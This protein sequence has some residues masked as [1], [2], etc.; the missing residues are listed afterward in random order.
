MKAQRLRAVNHNLIHSEMAGH[1]CIRPDQVLRKESL[2]IITVA[3]SIICFIFLLPHFTTLGVRLNPLQTT[4]CSWQ[5]LFTKLR[6]LGLFAA[7]I[8]TSV[9]L[10]T[11]SETQRS[12]LPAQWPYSAQQNSSIYLASLLGTF[13]IEGPNHWGKSRM[14]R[15]PR[16]KRYKE[17][18]IHFDLRYIN[19]KW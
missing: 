5:Q 16:V 13:S 4:C 2:A 18:N 19:D 15:R 14:P 7:A 17:M 6:F 12:F 3:T 9:I 8:M 10:L 1:I 11:V